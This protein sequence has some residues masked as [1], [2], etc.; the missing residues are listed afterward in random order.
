MRI[1]L[2]PG[3]DGTGAIHDGIK[4]ALPEVDVWTYPQSVQDHDQAVA[5]ASPR[6]PT[7]PYILVAESFSGATAVRLASTAPPGLRGVVL[8][9]SFLIPPR[10]VPPFMA[11][12]L[13]IMPL[14]SK[15]GNKLLQPLVMGRWTNPAMTDQFHRA[16]QGVDP[17]SFSRKLMSIQRLDV[18]ALAQACPVPLIAL[19]ANKDRLVAKRCVEALDPAQIIDIDAPH[20]LLQATPEA[21]A[22]EIKR[23][24]ASL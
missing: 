3:L 14:K 13:R 4:T 16:M 24:I 21:A 6:L 12:P 2:L 10:R 19:R 20:F 9:A 11:W 1:I 15:L 22:A 5:W 7:E 8:C 23:F 17:V 18:R